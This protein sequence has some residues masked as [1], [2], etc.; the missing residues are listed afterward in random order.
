[1][2]ESLTRISLEPRIA[3][4]CIGQFGSLQCFFGGR[5]STVSKPSID[6]K[7]SAAAS[8]H[9]STSSK[10]RSD[11]KDLPSLPA[12]VIE[13]THKR[14][15]SKDSS[16]SASA[17]TMA[18]G[19]PGTSIKFSLDGIDGMDGDDSDSQES[20]EPLTVT[21]VPGLLFYGPMS[22]EDVQESTDERQLVQAESLERN[23]SGEL[24]ALGT[25]RGAKPGV[26][27]ASSLSSRIEDLLLD[28]RVQRDDEPRLIHLVGARVH[29]GRIDRMSLDPD[30]NRICCW[31]RRIG[32][33]DA[34]PISISLEQAVQEMYELE[35]RRRNAE[36]AMYQR[37]ICS[38]MMRSQRARYLGL[39]Q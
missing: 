18:P 9:L 14:E 33:G 10:A 7:Q 37:Q 8:T 15:H 24:R 3:R 26:P 5:T 16:P 12:A 19:S 28:V 25:L 1:M 38:S 23:T 11:R 2:S 13:P 27:K 35:R 29:K 21:L 34:L 20:Q 31:V 32:D 6:S 36:L 4:R 39:D 22:R 17:S 30:G